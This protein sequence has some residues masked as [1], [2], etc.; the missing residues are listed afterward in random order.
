MKNTIDQCCFAVVDVCYD[1]DISD[2]LHDC[3]LNLRPRRYD[4]FPIFNL[5]VSY[6]FSLKGFYSRGPGKFGQF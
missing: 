6:R 4:N 3:V 2:T 1:C 5:Q